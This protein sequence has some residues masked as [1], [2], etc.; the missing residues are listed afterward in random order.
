MV[1]AVSVMADVNLISEEFA[2]LAPPTRL[3]T[4]GLV[5]QSFGHR[6]YEARPDYK[7]HDP[8][9]AMLEYG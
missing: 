6:G 9:T 3:V 5:R 7:A 8:S 4:T 1:C 2:V